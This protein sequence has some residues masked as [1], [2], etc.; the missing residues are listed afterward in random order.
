MSKKSFRTKVDLKTG[1]KTVFPIGISNPRG[2]SKQSAM[3]GRLAWEQILQDRY[4]GAQVR[5]LE[6]HKATRD[7]PAEYAPY[8][9]LVGSI[10]KA[11]LSATP[12]VNGQEMPDIDLQQFFPRQT[13]K[14]IAPFTGGIT[15]FSMVDGSSNM[16][17]IGKDFVAAITW[18]H[19]YPYDQNPIVVATLN[20]QRRSPVSERIETAG[21]LREAQNILEQSPYSISISQTDAGHLSK[22]MAGIP[23]D[24]KVHLIYTGGGDSAVLVPEDGQTSETIQI[25]ISR[26]RSS[27]ANETYRAG[28][29]KKLL[30][31]F[32]SISDTQNSRLFL[33]VAKDGNLVAKFQLVS[34]LIQG[35][36]ASFHPGRGDIGSDGESLTE[37]E[38]P[39]EL[40]GEMKVVIA[41][42]QRSSLLGPVP[43][44]SQVN[45]KA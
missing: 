9:S 27:A 20:G 34:P 11:L 41:P 25:P 8:V 24:E 1:R 26:I 3:A 18:D 2:F 17:T 23:D 45:E 5:V 40:K 42:A 7:S 31:S 35:E 15:V 44:E 28:T 12:Q 37:E 30:R 43:I 38:T 6:F 36:T 21:L 22:Q 32:D 19:A 13:D 33:N 16:V 29:L 14:V 4:P 39:K 10:A